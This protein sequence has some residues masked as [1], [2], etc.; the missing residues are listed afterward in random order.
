[1]KSNAT[2]HILHFG[3]LIDQKI[4]VSPFMIFTGNSGLGK[5][6]A[7]YLVYY[8]MRIF[9]GTDSLILSLVSKKLKIREK[10][11]STSMEI[12]LNE[13]E[14]SINNNV[15]N[16]MRAF[17]GDDRLKCD[18]KYHFTDDTINDRTLRI[19]FSL[20]EHNQKLGEELFHIVQTNTKINEEIAGKE[21]YMAESNTKEVIASIITRN[22]LVFLQNRI[23]G[24]NIGR[25]VILPPA[26]GAIVGESFSLKDSVTASCK[27]YEYFLKDY[28]LALRSVSIHML[29]KENQDSSFFVNRVKEL[30]HGDIISDKGIQYLELTGGKRIPLTAA[31]SSVKELSPFLFFLK[32]RSTSK[33]SFCIEEPEAHLHPSM[34]IDLADMIA[35]CRNKGMFFQMTTHSDYFIHRINQ[36]LQLGNLRRQNKDVYEKLQAE[37][38][39]NHRF[40]L[41]EEDVICYYFYQETDVDSVIIEQLKI[42]EGVLPMNTFYAASGALVDFERKLI[43]VEDSLNNG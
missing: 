10:Q 30:L 37:L 19:Q 13:I 22:V 20:S 21:M 31:A 33:L 17:L 8:L 32:N 34:Q 11:N 42:T 29:S 5:S 16:F 7:N 9:S 36:L 27:M 1:M 15:E 35:A 4:E 24:Q 23:F 2:I 3:P 41:N 40:Y 12:T 43:D 39:L 28:D 14:S 18:V 26:R 6:Y 38:K 25:A